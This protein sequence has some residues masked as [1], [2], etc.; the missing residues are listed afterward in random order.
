MLVFPLTKNIIQILGLF[1]PFMK[2]VVEIKYLTK[3]GFIMDGEKYE[4]RIGPI[5]KLHIQ[6]EWKKQCE[7]K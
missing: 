1:N 5:L 7:L 4:K 6:K 3:E 2:E